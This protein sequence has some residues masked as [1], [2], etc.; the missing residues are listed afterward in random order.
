MTDDSAREELRRAIYGPRDLSTLPVFAGG[1]INFGYWDGI[2]LDGPITV[3]QRIASQGALYD[4]ALDALDVTGRRVLEVG[5][6]RGVGVSRVLRRQ[7]RL[8]RGIDLVPEQVDRARRTA[9]DER[10]GFSVGS[11]SAIPFPDGSFDRLLSVE[12]AQHFEDL[13]GFARE[14]ARVLAPAGRLVVTTFFA[15]RD[16][17]GP[18]LAGLLETFASG[19]DLAHPVDRFTDDLRAAGLADVRADRIGSH[20]WPGLDRWVALG[21]DPDG[22]GR[23]WLVAV[24]RGLLDYYLVTARKPAGSTS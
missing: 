19:L 12:A 9:P 23:N 11:A 22:W 3:E 1:F 18:E 8:V 2:P 24:D 4:V 21:E 15:G 14:A 17:A 13:T 7:P 6:G 16:D 10:V 5:C 20:V